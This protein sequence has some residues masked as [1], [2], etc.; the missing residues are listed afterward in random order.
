LSILKDRGTSLRADVTASAGITAKF[1]DT[2]LIAPLLHAISRDT[3]DASLLAGLSADE[4]GR[5]NAG[6]AESVD[7]S[8]RA[9]VD[10]GL[11]KDTDNQAVFQYEIEPALLDVNGTAAVDRALK[12]DFSLLIA[13]EKRMGN[14]GVLGPGLKLINSVLSQ[15][16]TDGI[17]LKVNLLGIVNL[18]SLSKLMR[19][20]EILTDPAV[21][22]V[23]IKETVASERISAITVPL[24]RQEALRKAMFDSVMVT[25][26]YRASSAVAIPGMASHNLHFAV[27]QNTNTQTLSDY[28]GWFVGLNLM[29]SGEK[30]G[31]ISRFRPGGPSTCLM[32]TELN[33]ADCQRLFFNAA[34]SARAETEYLEI[35]RRALQALLDTEASEIDGFRFQF[36]D[37][38]N[39]WQQAVEMG[40]TPALRRLVPLNSTDPRFNTVLQ[41]VIGDVYDVVWWASSMAKAAAGIQEMREFLAGRDPVTLASDPEFTQKREKLQELMAGVVKRSKVRFHEPWGMVCLFWASGS[42]QASGKLT[43][44]SLIVDRPQPLEVGAVAGR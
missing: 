29:R 44:G 6:I 22:D 32:R 5:F 14:G 19:S 18:I 28:L 25:T 39:R 7:H 42:R 10:L 37:D 9:A 36:L 41:D 3:P 11:S 12:G 30:E 8:L 13:L 34:G 4:I 40:P 27:N 38:P 23:T 20:C 33:D 16:H 17:E 2:D 35:G 31:V 21:G 15:A 43:A 1:G 26:T 24:A